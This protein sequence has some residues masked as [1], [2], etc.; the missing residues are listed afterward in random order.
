MRF[1]SEEQTLDHNN[2]N[3]AACS[4]LELVAAV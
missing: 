2:Y 1:P 3:S 4:E